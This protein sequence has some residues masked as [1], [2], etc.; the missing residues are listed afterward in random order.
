MD[1]DVHIYNGVL[2]NHKKK[3]NCAICREMVGSR[4]CHTEW[5]KSET[6]KFSFDYCLPGVSFSILLTQKI[7]FKVS[8]L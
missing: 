8:F 6:H 1:K 2:L 7:T 4:D 3:W 5:S